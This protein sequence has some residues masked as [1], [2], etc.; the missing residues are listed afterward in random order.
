MPKYKWDIKDLLF[1]EDVKKIYDSSDGVV[2]RAFVS[3]CWLTGARTS[4]LLMLKKEDIGFNEDSLQ[5]RMHTLKLGKG[6]Y[7]TDLRTL[8]FTRPKGMQTSLYVETVIKYVSSLPS[9]EAMLFPYTS[10]WAESRVIGPASSKALSYVDGAGNKV[11]KWL[12]PYHFRHSV[13]QWFARNGASLAQLMHF[14]GAASPLSVQPYISAVASVVKLENL[15][16]DKA[17]V[18]YISPN[19]IG[20]KVE[21]GINEPGEANPEERVGSVEP[22]RKTSGTSEPVLPGEAA[23]RAEKDERIGVAETTGGEAEG[24]GPKEKISGS[25]GQPIGK[26]KEAGETKEGEETT[27]PSGQ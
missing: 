19:L 14:K 25:E 18:Q 21:A 1:E 4:E 12:T 16:R 26:A 23:F 13:M 11:E 6:K 10:R 24:K 17:L 5:V 8:T 2:K 9:S 27:K 7:K 20:V 3:L 22:E 15:N